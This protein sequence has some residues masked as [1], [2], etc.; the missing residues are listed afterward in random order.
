M[1]NVGVELRDVSAR[2]ITIRDVTVGPTAEELVA[3]LEDRGLL[4]AAKLAGLQERTIVSLARRLKPEVLDFEQSVT[5]LEH[6]VE[7]AL[8]VIARG[9]RGSNDDA[10]VSMVLARVAERVR[11]DDLDGGASAIDEALSELEAR[12]QR[13]QI[14]L[15]EEGVKIHTL[16]R[17][18]AAVARRIEMIVA[19]DHPTDR[20]VWH[21]E[22]RARY[23][24]ALADG[25]DKGINFSLSVAIELARR[26]V[27][28]ASNPD[29]RGRALTLFGNALSTLGERESG[30]ARLEQAVEAFDACLAV[31]APV[32]PP[33]WVSFVRGRR[34]L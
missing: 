19:V 20:P 8:D 2:D 32:W 11:S 24:E 30:T 3:V 10:F 29:E 4:V 13:S 25:T 27:A 16:R 34:D 26:M 7:V 22:F 28:T 17:D 33:E 31:T 15:L 21:P 23:D 14:A 12:H 1:S 5:E 18:A 9:E 6:A